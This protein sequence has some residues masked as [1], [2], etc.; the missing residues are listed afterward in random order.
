MPQQSIHAQLPGG[1][2]GR[3]LEKRAVGGGEE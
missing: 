3:V 1:G 2:R